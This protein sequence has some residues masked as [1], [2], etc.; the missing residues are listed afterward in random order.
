M[1]DVKISKRD[2]NTVPISKGDIIKYTV[3]ERNKCKLVNG[4]WQKLLS[5]FELWIT[6]YCVR[7]I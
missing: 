4:K 6:S 3:Q 1:I 7:D 5:E 2:Y